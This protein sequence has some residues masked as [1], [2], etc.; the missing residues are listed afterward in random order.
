MS[1]LQEL[2]KSGHAVE[3]IAG[4]RVRIN[5]APPKTWIPR[6][7][8][9][10]P[11]ILTALKAEQAAIKVVE[12]RPGRY[13]NPVANERTAEAAHAFYEHIM[14]DGVRLNCCYAPGNRYC[15]EGVML[16]NK[17]YDACNS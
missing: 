4:D 12:A 16:R 13:I 7:V 3:L 1:A 15:K 17:Y 14:G 11:E 8:E 2:R 5:P 10:K 9:V 6:L